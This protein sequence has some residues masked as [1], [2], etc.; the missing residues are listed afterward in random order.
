MAEFWIE[1][2][3]MDRDFAVEETSFSSA[4]TED[5]IVVIGATSELSEAT[6]SRWLSN[7]ADEDTLEFRAESTEFCPFII[8]KSL[9]N[10]ISSSDVL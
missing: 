9:Y 6:N 5:S 1:P 7:E 3:F 10:W 4:E 8:S 2:L